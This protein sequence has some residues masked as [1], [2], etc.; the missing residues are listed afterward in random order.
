M[1]NRPCGGLGVPFADYPQPL[2][3]L[4]NTPYIEEAEAGLGNRD[5]VGASVQVDGHVIVPLSASGEDT[6][7]EVI[8]RPAAQVAIADFQSRLRLAAGDAEHGVRSGQIHAC[9]APAT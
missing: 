8:V 2:Y 9:M 4:R 1:S 3:V 6:E 5:R 7:D